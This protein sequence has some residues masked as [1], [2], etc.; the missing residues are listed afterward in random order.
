MSKGGTRTGTE[1]AG[2][3]SAGVGLRYNYKKDFQLRF[4]VANVL[5]AGPAENLTDSSKTSD[6]DWRG[7]FNLVVGF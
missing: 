1:P 6:G 4:D 2:V 3:M 5:D 7:H